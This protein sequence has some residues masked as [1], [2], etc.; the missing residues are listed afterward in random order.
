MATKSWYRHNWRAG[1][2]GAVL[3]LLALIS[4]ADLVTAAGTLLLTALIASDAYRRNTVQYAHPWLFFLAALVALGMLKSG[5]HVAV[6]AGAALAVAMIILLT[7][8]YKLTAAPGLTREH[9]L[10]TLVFAQAIFVASLVNGAIALQAALVVVPVLATEELM[11]A[12]RFNR[13]NILLPF[14]ILT[15]IL[16]VALIFGAS[17]R[18]S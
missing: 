13:W 11:H 5:W 1:A 14:A 17:F 6:I 9:L 15:L 7:V 4:T 16:F 12:P 3:L 2:V 10:V 18:L 8:P